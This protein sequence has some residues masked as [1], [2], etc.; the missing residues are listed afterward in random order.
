MALVSSTTK[1]EDPIKANGKLAILKGSA[2]YTISL[3]IWL[4]KDTGVKGNSTAKEKL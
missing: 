1:T 2:S 3:V 4:I